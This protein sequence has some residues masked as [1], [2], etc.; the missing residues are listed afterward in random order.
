MPSSRLACR[1]SAQSA[2]VPA[3][4]QSVGHGRSDRLNRFRC[5]SRR[6]RWPLLVSLA[7]CHGIWPQRRDN[8]LNQNNRLS[9]DGAR[10]FYRGIDRA[11]PRIPRQR[12]DS[13]WWAP[14][15]SRWCVLRR[16]RAAVRFGHDRT[17]HV[18]RDVG[19]AGIASAASP[20]PV[21]T[22]NLNASVMVM[23]SAQDGAGNDDTDA[24]NRASDW[25]ILIQ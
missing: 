16:I 17:S 22:E 5:R 6:K 18:N 9:P 23:K 21:C 14:W 11:S 19:S 3:A 7:S 24:L 13:A 25:R 1:C 20:C 15:R 4:L 12:T 2:Q 10:R 8:G